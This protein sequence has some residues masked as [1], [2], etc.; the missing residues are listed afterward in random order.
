[1]TSQQSN[2]YGLGNFLTKEALSYRVNFALTT[3]NRNK[4]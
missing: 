1:M 3:C 4:G 2:A